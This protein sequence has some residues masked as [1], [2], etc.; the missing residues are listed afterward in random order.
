MSQK[1]LNVGCG[2]DIKPGWT[3]LDSV[4][5]PGVNVVCDVEKLPLPFEDNEFDV[6]QCQDI[7]EHIEYIPVFRDLHRVLKKG[8]LM[9]IR[10]PHFTS[11]RNFNDPT[12]KK[13]FSIRTFEYF[14]K[15]SR[16][17]RDYYFN[18]HFEKLI[19]SRIIFEKNYYFYNYFIEMVVNGSRKLKET[20]FEATFLSRL[21]PADYIVFKL[22][23]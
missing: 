17:G 21:F 5:L 3:N 2:R 19:Y 4:D 20:V 8:G 11:R 22:V 16:A 7:F 13:M 18:F 1:K 23:K 10:V 15:N 12:H 14:I 6:I 9:I